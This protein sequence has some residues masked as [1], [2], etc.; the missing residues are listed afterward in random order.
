MPLQPKTQNKSDGAGPSQLSYRCVECVRTVQPTFSLVNEII[1][2]YIF[3]LLVS[4]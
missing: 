3:K 4:G 1:N 2:E